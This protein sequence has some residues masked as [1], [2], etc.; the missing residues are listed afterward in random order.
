MSYNLH[1]KQFAAFSRQAKEKSKET[2]LQQYWWVILFIAIC[3]GIYAHAA[4][5]KRKSIV[6]LESHLQMLNSEKQYLLQEREEL[7]LNIQS[8]S[9][10]A[11]IELTL[12]KGLGLVPEGKV[13]VYF[14]TDS[15]NLP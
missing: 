3:F 2:A 14:D 11:W 12:M 15:G 7:L 8:Q 1:E 10:P 13:K 4:H 6:V 9:D 5:K